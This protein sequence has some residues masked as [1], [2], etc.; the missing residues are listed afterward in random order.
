MPKQ[1]QAKCSKETDKHDD[2]FC[3]QETRN[4]QF[5]RNSFLSRTQKIIF[6][7]MKIKNILVNF[8]N[9]DV[10]ILWVVGVNA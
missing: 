10:K 6:S 5:V 2:V 7:N 9:V 3:F 1:P 8:V 4:Q